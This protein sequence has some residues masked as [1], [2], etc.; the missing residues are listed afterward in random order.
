MG[1]VVISWVWIID[2][3]CVLCR[4]FVVDDCLYI[5]SILVVGWIGNYKMGMKINNEWF[6]LWCR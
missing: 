4:F 5:S 2:L 6:C 1:L 3:I